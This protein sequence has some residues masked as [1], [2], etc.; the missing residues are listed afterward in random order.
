MLLL[1]VG[2]KLLREIYVN[3]DGHLTY[4]DINNAEKRAEMVDQGTEHF[5]QELQMPC[6]SE[7]RCTSKE[8]N[9][10]KTILTSKLP[11]DV[12]GGISAKIKSA[13]NIA[14]ENKGNVGVVICGVHSDAFKNILLS[15]S[16]EGENC[17]SLIYK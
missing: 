6:I 9:D 4:F 16:A 12:T 10:N 17:T 3:H 8:Y 7:A 11:H 2:A 13:K 14:L 1:F 15:G 5:T